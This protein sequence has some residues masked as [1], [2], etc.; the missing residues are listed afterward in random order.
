MYGWSILKAPLAQAFGWST[1]ALA[2]NFTV[3]VCCFY[4][5]GTAGGMLAKPLGERVTLLL[6]GVLTCTGFLLT[7]RLSGQK[8]EMLYTSYGLLAGSGIGIAY[9][10]IISTVSTWFQDKKGMCSG[11]LLM[12]FGASAL[13]IGNLSGGLIENPFFG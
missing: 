9:N 10:V 2:L 4:L 8:V 5:G 3:T 11:T 12:G 7:A 13:A 6:A 1:S